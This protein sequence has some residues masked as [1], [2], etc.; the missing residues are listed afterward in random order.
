MICFFFTAPRVERCTD[1]SYIGNIRDFSRF[2]NLRSLQFAV[3]GTDWAGVADILQS[4]PARLATLIV[5]VEYDW[6]LLDSNMLVK[7]DGEL[8]AMRTNG[9]ELLEPVLLRD[10][11]KDLRL[12]QFDIYGY[13]NILDPLRE[14][15]IQ[16]IWL[17]LP[18]LHSRATSGLDIQLRFNYFP[19]PPP[20]SFSTV[21]N[22]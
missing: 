8:K 22:D 17:K 14:S 7:E 1:I 2:K 11:F 3:D 4:V 13:C 19:S 16:A 12:L 6:R 20:S 18:K 5:C 15:I 21:Q 9:L 10:N